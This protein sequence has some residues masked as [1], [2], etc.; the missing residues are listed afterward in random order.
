MIIR[1]DSL[2]AGLSHSLVERITAHPRIAVR[3]ATGVVAAQRDTRL[4]AVTVAEREG[5]Q[6]ELPTRAMYVLIGGEPL[7]SAEEMTRSKPIVEIGVCHPAA[8]VAP[9]AGVWES[10]ATAR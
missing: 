7:C 1:A 8:R 5:N 10:P 4:R 6:H 9:I 2:A 3:T